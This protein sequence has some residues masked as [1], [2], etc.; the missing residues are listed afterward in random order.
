MKVQVTIS[1][2]GSKPLVQVLDVPMGDI[3][4]EGN[5]KRIR[6]RVAAIQRRYP[7]ADVSWREI[8]EVKA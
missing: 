1:L 2:P 5:Q 3:T 4:H 6:R 7:Q 8:E